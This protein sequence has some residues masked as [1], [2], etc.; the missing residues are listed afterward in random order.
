M[1]TS[2]FIKTSAIVSS[3]AFFAAFAP[4]VSAEIIINGNGA[5]STNNVNYNQTTSSTISQQNNANVT[6]NVNS[7]ADTGGNSVKGNTGGNANITTGDA[8]VNTN[9]C[10]SLNT[11]V[12]NGSGNVSNPCVSPTVKPGNNPTPTSGSTTP[13]SNQPGPNGAGQPGPGG[14]GGGSSPAGSVQGLSTT[15]GENGLVDLLKLLP[16]LT[17][18]GIGY[19]LLRKHA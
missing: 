10:N 8:T 7:N 1:N 16:A 13:G 3:F 2:T 14:S 5:G 6:N 15:G 17:S 4:V 12:V 9:I 18:F 11:N 19:R